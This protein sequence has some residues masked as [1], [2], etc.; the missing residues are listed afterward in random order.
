MTIE[1][2]RKHGYDCMGVCE[3]VK[4]GCKYVNKTVKGLR[5]WKCEGRFYWVDGDKVSIV[6]N[7]QLDG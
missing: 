3:P 7:S 2:L 5:I 4:E 1:Y 6:Y